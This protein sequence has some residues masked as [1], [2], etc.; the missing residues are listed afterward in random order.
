MLRLRLQAESVKNR[1]KMA[2]VLVGYIF[3]VGLAG[4]AESWLLERNHLS[5]MP[6]DGL[7]QS[8]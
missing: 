1:K 7:I 6:D 4:C 3:V 2:M 8:S 5:T